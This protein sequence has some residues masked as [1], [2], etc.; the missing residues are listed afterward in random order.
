[1]IKDDDGENEGCHP[2]RDKA[3]AQM[4]ALYAS[5]GRNDAPANVEMRSSTIADVDVRQRL[6]DVVAVPWEEEAEVVWQGDVW[7]EVFQRG[8]FDGIEEH[9]G[10]VRVN[11][12]HTK[13]QTVGKVVKF[14]NADAGLLARTKIAKTPLG[15]ETL[16]LADEDAISASV[17]YRIGKPSDVQVNRRVKMR[18]VMRAFMD[19][20]SMVESPAFAGAQVLSV[21]AEPSGL[22]VVEQKLRPPTPALDEAMNDAIF[23]WARDRVGR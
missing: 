11:R 4:R 7:R 10:R 22:Q 20:L 23:A 15:E 1:V 2:T 3:R 13:G 14:T 9:A 17:G 18:R 5:E 12:E 16:A 6:I 8:A 19:H 21:R